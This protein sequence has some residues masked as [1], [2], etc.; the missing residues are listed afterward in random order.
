MKC[1]IA[2]ILNRIFIDQKCIPCNYVLVIFV[3]YSQA[4]CHGFA[5]EFISVNSFLL[6]F[7]ECKVFL[8]TSTDPFK[9]FERY[10]NRFET[11]LTV[12]YNP[13]QEYFCEKKG[14]YGTIFSTIRSFVYN[15]RELLKT[16]CHIR[17]SFYKSPPEISCAAPLDGFN[18]PRTRY[19]HFSVVIIINLFPFFL[20][21]R[22]FRFPPSP[23]LALL[24]Y[25]GALRSHRYCFNSLLQLLLI[26]II[27]LLARRYQ[28]SD[29]GGTCSYN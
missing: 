21:F 25:S 24:C 10:K 2:H 18:P 13:L 3:L 6:E 26:F 12:L 7:I 16:Y 4:H 9:V 8:E 1:L 14:V 29:D 17:H 28:R 20:R 11:H 27:H 15:I 23:P 5:L 22:N 19:S